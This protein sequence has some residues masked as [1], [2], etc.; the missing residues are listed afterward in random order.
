MKDSNPKALNKKLITILTAAVVGIVI[1]LIFGMR[2][3]VN[4]SIYSERKELLG[5]LVESSA[6]VINDNI[7]YGQTIADTISDNAQLYMSEYPDLKSY[8]DATVRLSVYNSYVF[9]FVDADGKYY[10]SDG[11]YGKITDT[12]Y[13]SNGSEEK[14]SY[15]STLPHM[16]PEDVYLIYRNRLAEPIYITTG[17]GET[18]LVY[19][20]ILY[21]IDNLNETVSQEFAG[22]NNTFIYNDTTGVMMYKSFGIKLL[23][24]GY[25]IYPKF[26]QSKII[27]GE[28]PE[29]L[30][31]ACR[32]HETVVAALNIDGEEF[33]FCSAP[34]APK[35]WSVSFIIQSKYLN[36]FSGNAFGR[37]VLY[38]ALI[39][40]LLGASVIY[41]VVAT[42]KNR[43][44]RKSNEEIT[45]LNSDLE[46]ATR[47]KSDFLSN[48][49]HDIRT[50]INGI[51]GMTTIAKNVPGNP[52]KTRECL[53]K[54][55]GASAHLLSLINDVLDMTR[56]ERGKT[57]IA[58][59]PID[60]RTVFDSCCSIIRGQ[61]S[62][63]NLELKTDIRCE[64]PRVFGDELHLRQIFINILGNA[65][66]FTTDGGTITFSCTEKEAVDEKTILCFEIEDTGIGMKPEFLEKIFDPFSQDEGG[67]R[68]E[69]KGTGLGMS[70]TKLLTDLMQG[71]VEVQS[72]YGKGSKFTV[73]IPF[74]IDTA[75]REEELSA[76]GDTDITGVRLLLVEDNELNMEIACELLEAEGA[77]ITQAVNGLQAVNLFSENAPGS[78]DVILMDVMMPVMNGIEA[79]KAIR[80]LDREDAGTVPILAMTANAF[81]SDIKATR[82]AGMNAHL[83]KPIDIDEVIRTIAR[84]VRKE[85]SEK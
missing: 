82:E 33:Y 77:I 48:M 13:Y 27:Y 40:V 39:F 25:N 80:A 75:E 57:E 34:I 43:T 84:H 37:I 52:E 24:D 42:Y 9:F 69:Y 20:G 8:I 16:D 64:H 41:L 70:I 44:I 59:S 35:D 76:P 81:E 68:S 50:P 38:I 15:I 18:E 73:T 12:T 45:K 4:T 14:L 21:D 71:T 51:I 36:D 5:R 78:F 7:A 54:I 47:A 60:I 74:V 56:I 58:S 1:L 31:A 30:E 49:S 26:S 65:V 79:A 10:S 85:H 62:E 55:E 22:E 11:T 46:S 67:A 29:A 6:L 3:S 23:I 63:R 19:S 32:N 2:K 61:I 17:H 66:K 83:S 53:G 28:A 72:E